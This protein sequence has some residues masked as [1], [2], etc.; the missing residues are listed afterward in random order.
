MQLPLPKLPENFLKNI[1]ST[2]TPNKK[3]SLKH[4]NQG[5]QSEVTPMKFY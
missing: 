1:A 4:K 2:E 3:L 5:F